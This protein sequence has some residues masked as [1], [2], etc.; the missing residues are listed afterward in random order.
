MEYSFF[1]M[2][3]EEMGD[4]MPLA[5]EERNRVLEGAARGEAQARSR[6]VEGSL[7]TVLEIAREYDKGELPISDLVQEANTA[8]MLAAVEYDGSEPWEELMERRVR[9]G[10]E[11]ALEEQRTE[12]QIEENMA[13]R[14]NVLQTVSQVMAQELGREA[15][16]DELAAKMKMSPDEI[17]D[18]MKLTLDALTVNGEGQAA[19]AGEEGKAVN[20]I[21]EGWSLDEDR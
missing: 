18:I 9:E 14:V 5:R 2:Y 3:L 15:T 10:V 16:V 20:P 4:I 8:L 17:K 19:G 12:N 21:K 1:D 11:L 7:K 6:L 13:A